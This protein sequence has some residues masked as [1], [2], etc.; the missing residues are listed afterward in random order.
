MSSDAERTAFARACTYLNYKAAAKWTAY[1][2]GVLMALLYVG[3]LVLLVLFSDVVV[4]RGLL[5]EYRELSANGR[6]YVLRTWGLQ[7]WRDLPEKERAA[8]REAED[9]R[10][11]P[12]ISGV[13]RWNAWAWWSASDF[14]L[15]SPYL[16]GLFGLAVL[17]VLAR[18]VLTLLMHEMAARSSIEAATRLRRAVYHH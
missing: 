10:Y 16:F 15:F 1:T 5:P 4:H 13:A 8:R 18:A 3:L 14:P 12:L 17:M 9:R 6:E 7:V 11:S 2:A